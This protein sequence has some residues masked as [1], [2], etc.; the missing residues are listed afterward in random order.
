MLKETEKKMWAKFERVENWD[1]FKK[2]FRKTQR[3]TT[4]SYKSLT[5]CFCINELIKT[6]WKE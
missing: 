1:I 3:K 6:Q 5:K 4:K 2:Q